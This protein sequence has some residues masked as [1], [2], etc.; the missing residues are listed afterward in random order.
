[1]LELKN[2]STQA[3]I[4]IAFKENN[5]ELYWQLI[6][7]LHKRGTLTEFSAAEKLCAS[8][9]P[10]NREIGADILGRLAWDKQIYVKASVD[11]LIKLLDDE[12]PDVIASA[13]YGLGH[14]HSAKAI[15]PLVK[16]IN[17]ESQRIRH[18]I[19][20]SL[21]GYEEEVAIEALIILS[22]D[23]DEEV[24]NWA[25][26]DLGSQIETNTAEICEAL[27]ARI[28]EDNHEIRGEALLGLAQRNYPD[29]VSLLKIELKRDTLGILTLEAST[30][31]AHQALHP[32]LLHWKNSLSQMQDALFER[33][34]NEAIQACQK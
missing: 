2:L 8:T 28:N 15:Q 3:I 9:N 23:S 13:A 29:I 10:I 19:T 18:A 24:R 16:L 17:H 1:M 7:E 6:S 12:N 33:Q 27:L 11:I 14:R 25:T 4:D 34:L 32:L 22:K 20:F 5:E 31:V 26:F 21:G 30:L